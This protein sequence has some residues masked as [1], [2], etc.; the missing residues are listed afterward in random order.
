[1]LVKILKILV[2]EYFQADNFM[3]KDSLSYFFRVKYNLYQMQLVSY[4]Q[5]N[6]KYLKLKFYMGWITMLD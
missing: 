1:M 2:E 6:F 4:F 5:F 3:K